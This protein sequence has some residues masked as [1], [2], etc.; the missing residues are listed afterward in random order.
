MEFTPSSKTAKVPRSDARRESR[1]P[2][3]RFATAVKAVGAYVG[4]TQ[5]FEWIRPP[6]MPA[7]SLR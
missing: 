7:Q 6:Q 5:P 2:T 1:R 4:R 3:A